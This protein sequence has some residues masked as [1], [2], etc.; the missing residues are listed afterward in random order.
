MLLFWQ[1]P[2]V[3]SFRGG[4]TLLLSYGGFTFEYNH[5]LFSFSLHMCVL[6]VGVV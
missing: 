5:V 1:P 6:F 3:A 4:N 2:S